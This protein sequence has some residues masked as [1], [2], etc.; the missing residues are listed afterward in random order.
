LSWLHYQADD[1]VFCHVCVHASALKSKRMDHNRSRGDL[2]L[3]DVV[4]GI[5]RMLL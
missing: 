3:Q 5:G 4:L 1:V 2:H